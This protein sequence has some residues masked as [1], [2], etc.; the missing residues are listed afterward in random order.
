MK[1][2]QKPSILQTHRENL[3]NL[4]SSIE[5]LTINFDQESLKK[6]K[7]NN[8]LKIEEPF[9]SLNL[10]ELR[11]SCTIDQLELIS[12]TFKPIIIA[13]IESK[14]D[15]PQDLQALYDDK[16]TIEGIKDVLNNEKRIKERDRITT[17]ID[18]ITG[19]ESEIRNQIRKKS[20]EI[21]TTISSDISRMWEILH[22]DE[23]IEDIKLYLPSD[24]DKA[25]EIGLKFYGKELESPRLT[26]SEGHRNS[27]G[28]CIFLSM[29]KNSN[30]K[31][32]PIFLD[33]VIVSFDRNHR[34]LV[35]ELL[36]KEFSERQILIL[37]HDRE[38]FIELRHQ[39]ENDKWEFETLK[40]WENPEI[41]I[42]FSKNTFS[43]D[44]ARSKLSNDATSAGN[45]CR[46]IMDNCLAVLCEKLEVRMK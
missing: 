42:Q 4:V 40:P 37:T 44:D 6:W 22:P 28:L 11:N 35:A 34:G 17:L 45:N 15:T 3:N 43:F 23:K 19:T 36:E 38:W 8:D 26:L 12:S 13:A 9:K 33:D 27:L 46:K 41:G 32:I 21:I 25:I 30:E 20:V 39:L 2:R 5:Q 7:E 18:F 16:N 29:A 14:K 24:T 1:C 31:D 10:N